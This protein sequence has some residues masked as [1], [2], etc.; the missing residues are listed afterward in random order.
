MDAKDEDGWTP[1]HLAAQNGNT[2]VATLLLKAGAAINAKDKNGKTP[3]YYAVDFGN[4]DT[5]ELLRAAGAKNPSCC[6][7]M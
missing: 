3:L 5:A 7:I 1:L 2:K 4:S 6:T